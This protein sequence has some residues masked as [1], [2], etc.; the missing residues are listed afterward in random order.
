MENSDNQVENTVTS[1]AQVEN[2]A[3]SEAQPEILK[4]KPIQAK[5][6]RIGSI[7]EWFNTVCPDGTPAQRSQALDSLDINEFYEKMLLLD[8]NWSQ[9]GDEKGVRIHFSWYKSAYKKENGLPRRTVN[10]LR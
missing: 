8:A 2:T 6:S 5:K 7:Y 9:R 3:V 4:F 1:E 10:K